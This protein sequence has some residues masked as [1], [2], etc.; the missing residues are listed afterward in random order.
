MNVMNVQN[1]YYAAAYGGSRVCTTINGIFA[2][3]LDKKF[4]LPKELN[5]KIK[6]L[7][8]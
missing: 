6:I 4:Y 8:K 5:K 7:L 2:L 3:G 1:I